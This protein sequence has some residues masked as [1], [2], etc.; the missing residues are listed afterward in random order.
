M[1][2]PRDR[3]EGSSQY[4]RSTGCVRS[5]MPTRGRVAGTSHHSAKSQGGVGVENR[6]NHRI[7]VVGVGVGMTPLLGWGAARLRPPPAA[8]ARI[9]AEVQF[10]AGFSSRKVPSWG[11]N[12]EFVR[13]AGAH[14]DM[15][16]RLDRFGFGCREWS[17]C[18][19]RSRPPMVAGRDYV[20][21]C[22]WGLRW[23]LIALLPGRRRRLRKGRSVGADLSDRAGSPWSGTRTASE[24][25]PRRGRS[26]RKRRP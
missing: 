19:R 1:S 6:R 21:V 14:R 7:P 2:E 26:T 22:Y 20:H 12:N 25:L 4:V 23:S 24:L 16:P 8:L 9:A 5:S 3:R 18:C 13:L 15:G 17:G 10:L 11:V